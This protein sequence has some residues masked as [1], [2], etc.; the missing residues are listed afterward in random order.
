MEKDKKME[1]NEKYN[2]K[3]PEGEDKKE[4]NEK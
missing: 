2:Y 3:M 1:E 4:N